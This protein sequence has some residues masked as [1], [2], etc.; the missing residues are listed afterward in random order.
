M[1]SCTRSTSSATWAAPNVSHLA[2][3]VV[4][5]GHERVQ[6]GEHLDDWPPADEAGQVEPVRPDVGDGP[7]PALAGRRRGASSSPCRAAASPGGTGR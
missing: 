2:E 5:L 1:C 6:V 4:A 3:R 7:Q